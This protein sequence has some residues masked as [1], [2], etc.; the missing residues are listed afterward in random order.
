MESP[1]NRDYKVFLDNIP[2]PTRPWANTWRPTKWERAQA[3]YSEVTIARTSATVICVLAETQAGQ[4]AGKL[5]SRQKGKASGR[6]WLEFCRHGE[7]GG[8]LPGNET[9]YRS[10]EG[11]IFVFLWLVLNWKWEQELGKLAVILQVLAIR[12]DSCILLLKYI[13]V[14]GI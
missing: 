7:A 3:I 1:T 12:A 9:S 4:R 13:P 11:S 6:P 14:S 2:C 8:R 10:G 5:H